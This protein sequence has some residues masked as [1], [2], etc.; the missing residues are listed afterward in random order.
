MHASSTPHW[1]PIVKKTVWLSIVFGVIAWSLWLLHQKLC[2]EVSSDPLARE[3]LASGGFWVSLKVIAESIGRSIGKVPNSGYVLAAL[4][5]L[6]AYVALAW[7]DRIAL[8]HLNR[9]DE[10]SLR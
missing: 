6:M 10:I 7:Y 3:M 1:L 2:H 8:L 4:S 9:Q 5:A